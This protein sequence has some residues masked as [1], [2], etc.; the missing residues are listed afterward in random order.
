MTSVVVARTRVELGTFLADLPRPRAVVM[1]MGALHE[2]HL[3][4]VRLAKERAETVVVTIFVNPLQFGPGEDFVEYPRRLDADI[5][6]LDELG[7]DVVFAPSGGEIYPNDEPEVLI[8]A[9]R[10]GEM[11]EGVSRPGHF[12][13]VLTVVAKFLHITQPD[14]AVF[15]EKDAQQLAL[16]QRMVADLDFPVEI[17]GAPTARSPEGLALSSRNAYL[18]EVERAQA[19][20]LWTA[21]SAA[22][23]NVTRG[24][25][26]VRDAALAVLT[27]AEG[28]ELDYL[29]L[30]DVLTLKEVEPDHR[31]EALLLI[32]AKVGT[33][34]LIDNA[35]LRLG[36]S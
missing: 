26:A 33:T 3:D 20:S 8:N 19:H 12:D 29:A 21:I 35:L 18:D 9:G 36:A 1:T 13:G 14:I 7:V 11:W 17:V 16:I 24:A 22:R 31:G 27:D 2:G 5:A 34:R 15:G 4:L 28:V 23:E 25:D 6:A 10:M 30:V 32:A